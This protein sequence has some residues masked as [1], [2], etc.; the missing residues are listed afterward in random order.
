M[1]AD[2]RVAEVT[3]D[4]TRP[5]PPRYWWLKR[6]VV[7]VI[8]LL[9]TTPVLR[10]VFGMVAQRRLDAHV[11]ELRASGEP[12][13]PQDFEFPAVPDQDNAAIPLKKAAALLVEPGNDDLSLVQYLLDPTLV[14]SK[15]EAVR[16]ILHTNEEPLR[17]LREARFKAGVDWG[18]RFSSPMLTIDTIVPLD[19]VRVEKL[20]QLGCL[21]AL[22]AWGRDEHAEA[23]ERILDVL[24]LGNRLNEGHP[25]VLTSLV[26]ATASGYALDVLESI[27]SAPLGSPALARQA[28]TVLLDERAVAAGFTE[29]FR[30]ERAGL[31][32]VVPGMRGADILFKGDSWS[33][34]TRLEWW[35]L[36][37]VLQLDGVRVVDHY[38]AYVDAS[39]AQDVPSVKQTLATV[40][41]S[42]ETIL[43]KRTRYLSALLLHEMSGTLCRTIVE[44]ARRR[45]A[46]SALAVRLYQD[47]HGHRPATLDELVPDYLP[48]VSLDPTSAERE[49][50]V[51]IPD[52]P[53][54]YV[55]F[56]RHPGGAPLRV[57]LV[58]RLCE[59]AAPGSQAA[60]GQGGDK[61]DSVEDQPRQAADNHN[62]DD[63][64]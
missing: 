43:E 40:G 20:A 46:A 62:P 25:F 52:G 2:E 51:Y 27:A 33:T 53:D 14:D 28:I 38:S 57:S 49:P 64:P 29:G 23:F 3:S 50:I 34:R 37:P 30:V 48:F 12:V 44:R 4:Q 24:D 16:A 59:G 42:F 36:E 35:L 7:A 17:L 11:T 31:L 21:A 55:G 41:L 9:L 5:I 47:D 8:L 15:E 63:Q 22:D 61:R 26:G 1:P 32:D 54:P 6:L 10:C 45:L 60:S 58:G 39:R 13:L 56:R 18:K 19:Q